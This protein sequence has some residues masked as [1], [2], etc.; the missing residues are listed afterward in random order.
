MRVTWKN[1]HLT[2]VKPKPKKKRINVHLRFGMR[3]R[4]MRQEIE[5]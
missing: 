1:V 4:M 2:F 5:K 3:R